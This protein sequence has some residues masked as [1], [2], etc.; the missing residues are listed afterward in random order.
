[1]KQ[2]YDIQNGKCAFFLEGRV[3]LENAPSLEK[4]LS[5]VL[6][7]HPDHELI[8]DAQNLIY[9]SSAGLRVLLRLIKGTPKRFVIRNVSE[10]VYSTLEMTGFTELADVKKLIRRIST[11]NCR[12]LGAGRSST[13]YQLDSET[14]VKKYDEYVPIE[15][16]HKE[17]EQA[18]KAFVFGIPTAIPFDLVQADESNGLVFELIAPADTVGKTITEHRER[19]DELTKKYT[20]LLKRIH[21]THIEEKD[22]FPATKD[23]WLKWLEGMVPYYS[24]TE[25]GFLRKMICSL[26]DR[27]TMVHCDFHE[28]N[29]LVFG[30]ELVLIDM[31]DIGYGHP[32]FDLAGLAFRA[33]AS[34]IPG[35]KA[36][37]GLSAEEMQLFYKTVLSYYFE[38]EDPERLNKIQDIC[39]AFGLV[40][41]ALFPMKHIHISDELRQLHINDAKINLF[42]KK[43]WAL[44]QLSDLGQFF[45]VI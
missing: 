27:N 24:E 40:R 1:M 15:K 5:E 35:R 17:M 6:K 36:H 3:T 20:E 39:Y 7:T 44:Q 33:H 34:L 25:I 38:T 32:V 14:I 8:I 30:N 12:V 29:V 42:T 31:A 19:F 21:H 37:H 23:I 11:D 41:S 45:T 18:R 13:V 26:P 22:N 4:K 28:N 9:I 10:P 16:I 2:E 43:D